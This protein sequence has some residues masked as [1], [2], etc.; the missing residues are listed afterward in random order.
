MLTHD[1]GAMRLG[2]ADTFV[3]PGA[4]TAEFSVPFEAVIDLACFGLFK[5]AALGV[6]L[7]RWA[8]C[9]SFSDV[10]LE[11]STLTPL[12][13]HPASG[14]RRPKANSYQQTNK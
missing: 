11:G 10:H 3:A 14:Y 4:A 7:S 8:G 2:R 6:G 1:Q 9:A 13:P 12:N 5:A